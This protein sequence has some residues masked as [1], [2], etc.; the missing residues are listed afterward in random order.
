M[1]LCDGGTLKE[2]LM[3]EELMLEQE[4]LLR[5]A[6]ETATGIAYLHMVC[7]IPS[8]PLCPAGSCSRCYHQWCCQHTQTE[9][10]LT[11]STV[12]LPLN[13]SISAASDA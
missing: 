3:D 2:L 9:A 7:P 1:E 6:A 8:L 4:E 11:A 13:R 12:V 10:S 5:L